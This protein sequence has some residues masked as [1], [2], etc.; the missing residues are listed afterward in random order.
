M[1]Q[2]AP[3]LVVAAGLNN[4]SLKVSFATVIFSPSTLATPALTPAG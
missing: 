2:P 4:T 3:V 1:T